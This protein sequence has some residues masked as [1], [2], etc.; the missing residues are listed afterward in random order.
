MVWP[1]LWSAMMQ[2]VGTH[3]L[4]LVLWIDQKES[5]QAV[6]NACCSCE[7]ECIHYSPNNNIEDS[8]YELTLSFKFWSILLPF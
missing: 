7:S 6:E 2:V 5:N 1:R 3:Y 8:R 4:Y